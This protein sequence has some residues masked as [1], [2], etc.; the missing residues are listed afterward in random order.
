MIGSPKKKDDCKQF[1]NQEICRKKQMV[2]NL[3]YEII[4]QVDY[5]NVVAA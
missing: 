3:F 5:L 4:L 1:R 2:R